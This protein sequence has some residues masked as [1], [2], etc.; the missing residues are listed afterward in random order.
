MPNIRT[1]FY[2]YRIGG[3]ALSDKTPAFLNIYNTASQAPEI[4]T[5]TGAVAPIAGQIEFLL[6]SDVR[7][8]DLLKEYRTNRLFSVAQIVPNAEKHIVLVAEIAEPLPDDFESG[9][10]EEFWTYSAGTAPGAISWINPVGKAT[11]NPLRNGYNYETAR[12]SQL[13][14]SDFDVFCRVS[15]DQGGASF[16]Y[17]GFRVIISNESGGSPD[18]DDVYFFFGITDNGS[19]KFVRLDKTSGSAVV[20]TNGLTFNSTYP[21][22][23]RL[24][25][26]GARLRTFQC[27]CDAMPQK[28]SEWIELPPFTTQVLNSLGRLSFEITAWQTGGTNGFAY[29]ETLRNWPRSNIA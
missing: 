5:R 16:R 18:P 14:T 21:V 8:G 4:Y 15:T 19:G 22:W 3:G 23:I 2:H 28:E 29:V 6:Q 13:L 20:A 17:V 27:I 26:V 7:V 1:S 24:R 10:R 11:F 12:I 25:R 9:V